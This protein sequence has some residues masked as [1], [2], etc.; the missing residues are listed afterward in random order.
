[1]SAENSD[2]VSNLLASLATSLLG[3]APSVNNDL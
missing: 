3:G 2:V 1:M